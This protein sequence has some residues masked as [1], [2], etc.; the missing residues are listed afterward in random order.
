MT[1]PLS[2]VVKEKKLI[3]VG[4]Q[5]RCNGGI[6]EEGTREPTNTALAQGG[7]KK[8]TFVQIRRESWQIRCKD[9]REPAGLAL[10]DRKKK[11][12][13]P[14]AAQAGPAGRGGE[15]LVLKKAKQD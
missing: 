6:C 1:P 10:G 13:Q 15:G 5:K 7:K 12:T 4:G 14:V 2:T 9:T 11:K 3:R 8:L